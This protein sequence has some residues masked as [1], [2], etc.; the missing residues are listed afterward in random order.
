VQL[1]PR[2]RFE[3][4]VVGASNRLAAA[5]ARAVAQSPGSAYNPL[6][7][8]GGS[9]LGKTHLL[10]AIGQQTLELH[11]EMRVTYATMEEFMDQLH[12][13]ISSG[14]TSTFKARYQDVDLLLL[15]DVQFLAGRRETQSEMLR[16]FNTLQRAG[17][18]IALA[19]DRPPTEISDLDERLITRFSGGLVVDMSIPDFETR[20]AILRRKCSE[21]ETEFA[22][23]VMEEVARIGYGNVR[24]LQ[25][26]L[27]RLIACQTLGR[28]HVTVG[29]VRSLLGEEREA[30]T[31]AS[32]PEQSRDEFASF[33]SGL[34][35]AVAEHLEPWK[36][37]I[38]EAITYWH[39]LGYRTT[40]LERELQRESPADPEA[41]IRAFEAGVDRLRTLTREAV[42]VNPDFENE[43][44]FR[45][46]D[47]LADAEQLVA[48]L[49]G[50][51]EP[52]PGPSAE[53]SRS[54]YESGPS[55][56][57]AVHAADAVIESPGVAYNPLYVHGPSS[58][59]KTH[60]IHA[61]ASELVMLSGGAMVVAC[62][63]ARE[64][65]DELI[66][67]LQ[68]G[69]IERW[70]SRYRLVDALVVDD[71]QHCAG[72]ERAQEE[73]FN[74][75]NTLYS[76]GRQIIIAG[77]RPAREIEGMQDRLRSRFE[78]GLVVQLHAPDRQLREKLFARYLAGAGLE[79][80]PEVLAYLGARP[81][82]TVRDIVADV[83]VISRS[84]GA[85]GLSL[86]VA[87]VRRLLDGGNGMVAAP[88]A[89]GVMDPTFFDPERLVWGWADVPG[90]AVEEFR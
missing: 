59:G 28:Q 51:V 73:L 35:E 30:I 33:L 11:P 85:G 90:R 64:F 29:N 3:S 38:G 25:G 23:G 66:A 19:S 10:G 61:I 75:F 50:D 65:V 86:T 63:N 31:I 24:E 48:G 52:P 82:A 13:A 45:D 53:F 15:D 67:A 74:L 20:V 43:D 34:N 55:N 17:R 16:L 60:L 69:T 39:E 42:A 18:Q 78:G 79:A 27:N 77:D 58:A 76:A 22:P 2:F 8:Y 32:L 56:Q 44:L 4:F 54:E 36:A 72:T 89:K 81:A 9:G 62:V 14:Q 80:G 57:L 47:R 84:T 1:D 88:D 87:F 37:R 7:V 41:V 71:V 6:F 49:V 68:E 5:A 40:A 21:R 46:P 83:R 70:R 12:E 26:A